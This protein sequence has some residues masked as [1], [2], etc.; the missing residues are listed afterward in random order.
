MALYFDQI[1]EKFPNKAFLV[2]EGEPNYNSIH[3]MWK[4]LYGNTSTLKN[5]LYGGNKGNISII[6]RYMIYTKISPIPCDAPMDP[7]GKYKSPKQTTRAY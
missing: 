1:V 2:I 5:K 3:D 6:M 7:G 4:L